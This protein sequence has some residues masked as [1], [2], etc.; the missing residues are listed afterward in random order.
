[1]LVEQLIAFNG[2]PWDEKYVNVFIIC[3]LPAFTLLNDLI[4]YVYVGPGYKNDGLIFNIWHVA[5]HRFVV[6]SAFLFYFRSF[7]EIT[8]NKC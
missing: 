7:R 5:V 1:V 6:K 4:N 2:S 8:N 3:F